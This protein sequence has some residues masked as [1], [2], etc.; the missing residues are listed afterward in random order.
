M[1]TDSGFYKYFDE[2]LLKRPYALVAIFIALE[3]DPS[4]LFLPRP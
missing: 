2:P 1:S 4:I 3:N